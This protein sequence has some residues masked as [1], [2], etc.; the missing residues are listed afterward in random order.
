[1]FL[2]LPDPMDSDPDPYQNVTNLGKIHK[3]NN[4]VQNYN[5]MHSEYSA[6]KDN[7]RRGSN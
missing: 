1:M 4:L 3:L 7:W 5:K 2:G 6:R